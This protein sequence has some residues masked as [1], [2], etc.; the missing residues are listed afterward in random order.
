MMALKG[1][2]PKEISG[3]QPENSQI[4]SLKPTEA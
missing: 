3:S 4:S 2:K 1:R